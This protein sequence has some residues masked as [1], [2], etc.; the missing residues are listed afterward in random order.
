MKKIFIAAFA[1]VS[2][3][4][5]NKDIDMAITPDNS[6]LSDGAVVTM[7]FTDETTTRAFFAEAATAETWEKSLSALSVYVFNAKGDLITERSFTASELSAKSATFAL[8]HATAGTTCDF[9]AVANMSLS[10]IATKSALLAKLETAAADYNGTFAEV[11][12]KAKRSGGFVMS[13]GVSKA[14]A[15]EGS[16]TSVALTLKRTV[17]KVAVKTSIDAT[18]AAKY[19]GT[20]TVTS[21]K[22]LR[23]ASQT[24]IIAPATPTPG[25]MT[26]THTQ[27]AAA[28][29]GKFNNLF[30]LFENGALAEASRVTLE[31]TATYDADGNS[32]TTADRME[33][34]YTVPLTGKAGGE[35]TRNGYYRVAANL[36][37]LVGQDCQVAVS[38]A[39]WETPVTQSVDLGA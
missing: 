24:P 30:Y 22:L 2:L 34:V 7:T 27:T 28:A 39:E 12:T 20:L 11:S 8:P 13:A 31:I 35:I 21:T 38:V 1:A 33:V 9:Y 16:T 36:T 10:G 17:A 5:C 15:A 6:S 32:S 18:F 19:S 4:A 37:G 29:S 25:A 23:A 3:I 26:Y 14:V